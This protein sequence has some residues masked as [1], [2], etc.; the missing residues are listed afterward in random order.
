MCGK[1]LS[2]QISD[3]YHNSSMTVR[4]I[5]NKHGVCV[6]TVYNIMHN[7]TDRKGHAKQR[8]RYLAL[9]LNESHTLLSYLQQVH[10]APD[11]Q[12]RL[13][14]IIEDLTY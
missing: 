6:R 9:T 10:A 11:I 13:E 4:Q 5:A 2:Q 8:R 3:D 7:K 1:G 12:A 14:N